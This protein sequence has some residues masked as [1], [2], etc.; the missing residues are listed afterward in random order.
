MGFLFH[1][2]KF[3]AVWCW[4]QPFSDLTGRQQEL[5]REGVT[6]NYSLEKINLSF[7]NVWSFGNVYL[8]V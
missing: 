2:L 5:W 1:N 6:L 3:I 8:P 7:I 4:P